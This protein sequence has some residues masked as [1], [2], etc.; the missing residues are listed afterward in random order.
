[1]A[2]KVAWELMDYLLGKTPKQ[3]VKV[4]RTPRTK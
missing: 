4:K 2:K 1:M 3:P